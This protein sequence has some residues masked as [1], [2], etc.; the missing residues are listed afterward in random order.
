M[1]GLPGEVRADLGDAASTY[2][3]A[4]RLVR[5]WRHVAA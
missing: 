2:A 4:V 3:Q 5:A 1:S